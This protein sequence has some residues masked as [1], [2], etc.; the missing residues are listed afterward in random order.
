MIL[1]AKPSIDVFQNANGLNW[2]E[3]TP[4]PSSSAVAVPTLNY[5]IK[6]ALGKEVSEESDAQMA[7]TQATVLATCAPLANFWSHLAEQQLTEKT[8]ETYPG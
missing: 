3:S 2:H 1:S 5:D 7:K 8:R 4:K 6:G